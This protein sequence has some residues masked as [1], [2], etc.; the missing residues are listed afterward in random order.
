MFVYVCGCVGRCVCVSVWVGWKGTGEVSKKLLL[1]NYFYFFPKRF[2]A[3]GLHPLKPIF[4]N[5]ARN[6]TR[7]IEN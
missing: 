1:L 3:R 5:K 2:S 7:D 4:H 6:A